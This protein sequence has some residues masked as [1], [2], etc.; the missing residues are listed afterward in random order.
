MNRCIKQ[1]QTFATVVLRKLDEFESE[2]IFGPYRTK[3]YRRILFPCDKCVY[4]TTSYTCV[5][6]RYNNGYYCKSH[7]R[8][9]YDTYYNKLQNV[10]TCDDMVNNIVSYI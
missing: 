8:H 10:F 1:S 7:T 9:I 6:T 2:K 4:V 3:Y 5:Y